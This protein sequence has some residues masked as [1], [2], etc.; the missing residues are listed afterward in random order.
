M[1][2][3]TRKL[4][5][6]GLASSMAFMVLG[7]AAGLFRLFMDNGV[8]YMQQLVPLFNLHSLFMVFGFLA[9]LLM[10]ERIV[11]TSGMKG[12]F[13]FRFSLC[14]LLLSIGGLVLLS[15]GWLVHSLP[16][17]VTGG[18]MAASAAL[19]FTLL[20]LRLGRI[21]DDYSSFAIMSSGTVSLAMA[22]VL[23]G[24]QLPVDN[25]PLIVLMLLFP[26]AF[27]LG[28]RV[29]LT[30]FQHLPRK[31]VLN[32]SLL[33]FLA[34]SIVLSFTAAVA[35]SP[36]PAGVLLTAA[37]VLVLAG[38]LMTY[39]MERKRGVARGSRLQAYVGTGIAVAYFWLLLGIPLLIFRING[40]TGL[41]DPAVHSIALGFIAT[42]IFAHGPVIFPTVLERRANIS[43]LSYYPLIL[44]TV[45][46]ILRVGGDL[47]KIP[48]L[49]AGV[50][51]LFT[52]YMTAMSGV[53]LAASILL[54]AIMMRG[55]VVRSGGMDLS[56][57]SEPK[58]MS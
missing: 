50:A 43:K 37:L 34:S 36:L 19:L 47:A 7:F 31:G 53:V 18:V 6:V 39:T 3:K 46:N 33:V 14:M 13:G 5:N 57:K 55:L 12:S 8:P 15:I 16:L 54:F 28:E 21:A 29:E 24:F 22:S 25:Y 58:Q 44:L 52:S 51:P 27:V 26:L 30:K 40:V 9:C 56:L 35:G 11:G 45:S 49:G 20:L 1:L 4:R 48:L 2:E 42:F 32:L 41:Y 38:S 23:S 10:T 17:S